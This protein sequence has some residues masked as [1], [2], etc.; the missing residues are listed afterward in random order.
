MAGEGEAEAGEG[1]GEAAGEGEEEPVQQTCPRV[2]VNDI[3][4]DPLNVRP[5]PNR[6]QAPVLTLR[7]FEIVDVLDEV[8]GEAIG[9]DDRWFEVAK[10]SVT[11]FVAA[12]FVTCTTDEVPVVPTPEGFV[13]PFSCNS[14]VTVTQGN[15]S[16]FSHNGMSAFAFD[17]GVPKDTPLQAVADGVV[18]AAFS[19]VDPSDACFNGGGS[20][21]AN[22]VNYIA[23]DHGDGTST[24]YLHLNEA[25]L[26][27][28]EVVARGDVIALSGGTGW[29]TGPHTHVQ[30]QT[31]C[32]SW[33]CQS[34]A[35][36][37]ADVGHTPTAGE[38]VHSGNCD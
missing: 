3:G 33:W 25:L 14:S 35:M 24:L 31:Q 6:E 11:G 19:G 13:L 15:N 36:D 23:I 8:V 34:V 29:S 18:E 37:F 10:G 22:T 20:E 9:G 2:R 4:S 16:A 7:S 17:F 21:C 26:E 28:G 38:T 1:E 5:A 30:R 12:G 27:A 32:G